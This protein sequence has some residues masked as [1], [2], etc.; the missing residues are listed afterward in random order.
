L[1]EKG[2]LTVLDAMC[3]ETREPN[4]VPL[5][6]ALLLLAEVDIGRGKRLFGGSVVRMDT[7]S[8]VEAKT[9][10]RRSGDFSRTVY[11]FDHLS[12]VASLEF[13]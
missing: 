13:P 10:G 4:G 1:S 7:V 9:D 11:V 12:S 6:E 2:L 5:S 3:A 8:S